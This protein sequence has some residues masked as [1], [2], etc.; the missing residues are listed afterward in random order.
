MFYFEKVGDTVH[1]QKHYAILSASQQQTDHQ[2]RSGS[3]HVVVGVASTAGGGGGGTA[4]SGTFAVEADS[5][6]ARVCSRKFNGLRAG[7][8]GWYPDTP[9]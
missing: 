1:S 3:K 8:R 9:V 5:V 4:R 7:S 6:T 2:I